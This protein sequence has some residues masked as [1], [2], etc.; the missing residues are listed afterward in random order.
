MPGQ[1]RIRMRGGDGG[2]EDGTE[3][4]ASI[5]HGT[6]GS[7]NRSG[8]VT[9]YPSDRAKRKPSRREGFHREHRD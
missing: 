3:E 2:I 4:G 8:R 1:D 5:G 6:A 9:G 7:L